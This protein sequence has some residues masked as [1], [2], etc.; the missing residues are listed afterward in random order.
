MNFSKKAIW[1]ATASEQDGER[2]LAIAREHIAL[3]REISLFSDNGQSAGKVVY[4]T[5]LDIYK[6]KI[7][8]LRQ[9]RNTIIQKYEEVE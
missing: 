2:L 3:A 6:V 4:D 5:T 7:E 8:Q 9:E 1:L